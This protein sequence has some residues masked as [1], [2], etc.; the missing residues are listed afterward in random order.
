MKRLKFRDDLYDLSGGLDQYRDFIVSQIDATADTVEFTNGIIIKAGEAYGDL[1]ERDIRRI[2]I[3][4]TIRAHLE[5]ERQ[6]FAQGVKVLSLFFI[7]EVAK[8]RDYSRDDQNGEYARMFEEEYRSEEHT[9][10]L[11]SLMRISY[12]VFCLK[13]KT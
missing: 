11:K 7:D 9:S 3:R 4:E 5:K 8:Y 2:Q 1:S 10:E 6:L 12:A 13:K